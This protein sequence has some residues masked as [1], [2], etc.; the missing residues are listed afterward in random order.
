ME[1]RRRIP[2]VTQL[3][4]TV[5]VPQA[6]R[7]PLGQLQALQWVWRLSTGV[8]RLEVSDVAA[9]GEANTTETGQW[10]LST[11]TLL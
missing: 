10:T 6:T 1:S 5:P 11:S 7:H 3:E 9:G 8:R 4:E 2:A